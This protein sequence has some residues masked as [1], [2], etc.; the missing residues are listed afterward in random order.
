MKGDRYT[1][2]ERGTV[3]ALHDLAPLLGPFMEPLL[4]EFIARHA[5]WR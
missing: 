5:S 3:V 1:Q 2:E 4:G